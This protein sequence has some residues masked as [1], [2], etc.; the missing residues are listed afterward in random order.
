MPI[1]EIRLSPT[2]KRFLSSGQASGVLLLS[3]TVVSLVIANS[4]RGEAYLHFWHAKLGGLPVEAW[5]ND[6]LMAAFFLL[7]G[8]ELKR[9]LCVGELS[10]VRHALLPIFAALGGIVVPATIHFTLNNGTVTQPGIGIPMATDIA[11][12]LGVLALLGDR[13][14]ASLK[15]FLAALA[16]IDDLGAIIVI[17]LFYSRSLAWDYLGASLAIFAALTILNRLRVMRVWP[18][19]LV[20]LGLWFAMLKS[21]VHATL[22]GVLLAFAIPFTPKAEDEAS[23]SHR[24]E[25]WLQW[26]VSFGV[27][28]LFALANTGIIIQQDVV[29]LI[30]SANGVGIFTGLFIGK[31]VGIVFASVLA[32]SIGLCRMPLDL[33]WKHLLGAGLLGGI[34][35][36]MSIFITNLA[37]PNDALTISASKMTI[38]LASLA[39]GTVGFLWLKFFGQPDVVDR[40]L[41][42]MDYVVETS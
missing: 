4:S 32:I 26:P 25:K 35:F 5:I 7:I 21:G 6:G 39:A 19:L 37:F 2:F 29:S 15:V 40:D 36:T 8:L 33:N 3:C 23:P 13:V 11:F 41:E 34:G 42:T 1:I 12:A 22:A 24:L 20:G 31:P 9:E 30:T 16:V 38:L 17:A 14:P 28:P 10:S 27:M 18:Y